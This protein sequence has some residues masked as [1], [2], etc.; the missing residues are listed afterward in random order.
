MRKR[1]TASLAERCGEAPSA[2]QVK[3]HNELTSR[4]PRKALGPSINRRRMSRACCL[5]TT[6][7]VAMSKSNE[8]TLDAIGH[9]S[10]EAASTQNLFRQSRSPV[11]AF[12]A[13]SVR[14]RPTI[15]RQRAS[16]R[17]TPMPAPSGALSLQRESM[18]IDMDSLRLS[19]Q[20][21][22]SSKRAGP[23]HSSA[24]LRFEHGHSGPSLGSRPP[25]ASTS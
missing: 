18:N 5:S 24:R 19:L 23:P 12:R 2:R 13:T 17:I 6:R 21:P 22:A 11:C 25:L 4:S 16:P 20:I 8:W 10:A 3:T 14:V 15:I 9:G 7:T 1:R